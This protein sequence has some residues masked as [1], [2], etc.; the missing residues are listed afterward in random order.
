MIESPSYFEKSIPGRR[1]AYRYT[2]PLQNFPTAV[3]LCGFRSDMNGDKI[4]FLEGLCREKGI[5]FLTFDYSGHGRSSGQFKEGTISQWLADSLDI[6]DHLTR[7]PVIIIGSSMGGWL[8]HWVALRRPHRIVSLLGI[9]SAPDFTER[10]MWQKFTQNQKNEVINQGWT[11]IPTTYDPK[12][13]TITKKLI[14]D[15]RKHLLLGNPIALDIPIRLLHG[16]NDAHV[17]A[18]CSRQLVERVNSTDVTLTLIK[19]GDHRLSREEDKRILWT[20]LQELVTR[21]L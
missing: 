1:L 2:P 16:L 3:Y 12:G 19:S 6:I 10:L 18:S 11:V 4:L 20:L 7:G 15:G 14:E 5:G 17:P 8:A 13:W 9:A 21:T